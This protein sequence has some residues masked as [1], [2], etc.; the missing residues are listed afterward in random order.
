[1]WLFT[2]IVILSLQ[3]RGELS[4][5]QEAQ[6]ELNKTIERCTKA[7]NDS[8]T[9]LAELDQLIAEESSNTDDKVGLH[10]RYILKYTIVL[11][12][13]KHLYVKFTYGLV[14]SSVYKTDFFFNLPSNL[15]N[16]LLEVL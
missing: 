8:V 15:Y 1:M 16:L 9:S 12:W 11:I 13:Q 6:Q 10:T 4:D 14:H 3:T 2:V 7:L 5:I